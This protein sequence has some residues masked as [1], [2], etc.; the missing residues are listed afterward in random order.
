MPKVNLYV[1]HVAGTRPAI[2]YT[3]AS[4]QQIV[5]SMSIP[6]FPGMPMGAMHL[7]PN[8]AQPTMAGPAPAANGPAAAPAGSRGGAGNASGAAG[9]AAAAGAG[10]N[11]P[12]QPMGINLGTLL[13]SAFGGA[14]GQPHRPGQSRSPAGGL[15]T[16]IARLNS[17]VQSICYAQRSAPF[18]WFD[19]H[20]TC[21]W[22]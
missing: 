5:T 16:C 4:M 3:P 13:Q 7:G 6:M 14:G 8:G 10:A 1:R 9:A 22:C 19:C 20:C 2:G 17:S 18:V 15:R 11:R 12:G 21:V